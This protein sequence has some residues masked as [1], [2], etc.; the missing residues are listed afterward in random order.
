MRRRDGALKKRYGH[1][2]YLAKPLAFPGVK[3]FGELFTRAREWASKDLS[4]R[5]TRAKR[6][7]REANII[8]GYLTVSGRGGHESMTVTPSPALVTWLSENML[9]LGDSISF[10][11]V[12]RSDGA[13]VI[14][15]H[16]KIIGSRW[17]AMIDPNTIP[18]FE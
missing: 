1:A 14:A 3:S 2:G 15:K 9:A 13:L 16:S 8:G 11:I 18:R 5:G 7:G 4:A 10:E 6:G 12:V 17:L